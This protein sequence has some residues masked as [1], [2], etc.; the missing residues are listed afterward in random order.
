MAGWIQTRSPPRAGWHI[1][2]SAMADAALGFPID[3]HSGGVDLR[4][5]H[6]E[7]EIA[8]SEA[9][10]DKQHWVKYFLHSGHLHIHGAKMSKSLK[11]FVSIK[12][13]LTGYSAREVR[14]L[15]LAHRWD[16]PMNYHPDGESMGPASEVD[17]LL[18]N[19]FDSV[20]AA[21]RGGG[22]GGGAMAGLEGNQKW[23]ADEQ[24][25]EAQLNKDLRTVSE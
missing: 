20:V 6:H 18:Q 22:G 25:L 7:N 1:E 15:F 3:I 17:R 2:C 14:L 10:C 16:Q 9:H 23:G 11:N 8:Q 4:F 21:W 19:F 24:Q 5:P 12:E 13:V